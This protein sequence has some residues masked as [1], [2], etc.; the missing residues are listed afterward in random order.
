[1]PRSVTKQEICYVIYLEY[2]YEYFPSSIRLWGFSTYFGLYPT[3]YNFFFYFNL[4]VSI[5]RTDSREYYGVIILVLFSRFVSMY[6][7][8]TKERGICACFILAC[9]ANGTVSREKISRT[10]HANTLFGS[11]HDGRTKDDNFRYNEASSSIC[12]AMAESRV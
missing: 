5:L 6:R 11:Y 12:T 8:Q 1:M 7:D 4:V 10:L 9:I 2:A 3:K